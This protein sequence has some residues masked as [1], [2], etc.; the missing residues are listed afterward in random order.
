MVHEGLSHQTMTFPFTIV[1]SL[2][3]I[4]E[5]IF[6]VIMDFSLFR[7][8]ETSVESRKR[9]CPLCGE[10]D[11]LLG[12]GKNMA[13]IS[14]FLCNDGVS[15][16]LPPFL[17]NGLLRG[18]EC[19][20]GKR[21]ALSMFLFSFSPMLPTPLFFPCLSEAVLCGRRLFSS[22]GNDPFSPFSQ[23]VAL[24]NFSPTRVRRDLF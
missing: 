2:P 6:N 4:Y 8:L 20:V 10:V 15:I 16:G 5:L 24:E 21:L 3:A 17:F 7:K 9:F 1:R 19:F 12:A 18:F 11:L 13:I 14:P 23:R 22:T